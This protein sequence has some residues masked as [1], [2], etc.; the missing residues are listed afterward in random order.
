MVRTT[1]MW[2]DRHNQIEV[3]HS[4][5]DFEVVYD[6]YIYDL[7]QSGKYFSSCTISVIYEP[8]CTSV[9]KKPKLF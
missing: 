9:V 8:N 1:S 4:I 5:Y 2:D 3:V 7:P 6:M